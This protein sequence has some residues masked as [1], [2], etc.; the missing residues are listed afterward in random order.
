MTKDAQGL[1]KKLLLLLFLFGGH[2]LS[3][4]NTEYKG[5]MCCNINQ[6]TSNA[7]TGGFSSLEIV[8]IQNSL[9]HPYLTMQRNTTPRNATS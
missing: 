5:A 4:Y 8:Y 3:Q 9:M 7:V 2:G 1:K 6:V